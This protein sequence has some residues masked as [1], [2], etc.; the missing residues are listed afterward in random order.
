[1]A[2]LAAAQERDFRNRGFSRRS[3]GR[4]AALIAAGP[5][6]PFYNE[7][8][9]A[10]RSRSGGLSP[11]VVKIDANENPLGPCPEAAEAMGE[12]VKDGGRYHFDMPSQM[13]ALMAQ[14]EG[15]GSGYVQAYP[16]SSMPLHWSVLAFTSPARPFVIAEPGYEAG[17]NAARF[18]GARV[19]RV[20]LRKDYSHDVKAMAAADPNTGLIYVCNPNNPTGTLTSRADLEYLLANK[21]NGAI[22]L[23]DEAYIHFSG[24][25]GASGLVAA[26]KD[27]VI[28]RT[29]SKLYGM[30][31]LRAG[32]ALARPDLLNKIQAY[33][34]TWMPITSVA[35][36]MAS[37]RAKNLIAERRKINQDTREDVFG[38]LE[39]Q[40]FGHTP[41]VANFFMMDVKRP[42][43]E[44]INALRGEGVQVGRL[45]AVWPNHVRVTVGTPEEMDKFKAAFR[46]VT[47]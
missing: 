44:V 23:L 29:F 38:F 30:A 33:G 16:G 5:A 31:G 32:A 42:G 11:G 2:T 3:F 39:K 34:N 45:W 6:L 14:V 4:L 46:T 37:L 13:H 18:V 8:A 41:S 26:G 19:I 10:Q 22:V 7:A 40:G 24:L 12:I 1:M 28:L 21:P 47:A 20:P 35:G 27:L 36:A 43:R 17:A 25:E 15:L 9:L